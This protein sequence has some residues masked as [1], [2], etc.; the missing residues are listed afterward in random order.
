[1]VHYYPGI[2]E[3]RTPALS[4]KIRSNKSHLPVG[5]SYAKTR[6]MDSEFYGNY[7]CL[8]FTKQ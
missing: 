1:M 2:P 7:T 3:C 8:I 4:L 6:K 5:S